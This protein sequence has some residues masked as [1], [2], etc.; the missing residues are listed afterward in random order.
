MKSLN[1][2]AMALVACM[3]VILAF[4]AKH[5]AS[6]EPPHVWLRDLEQPLRSL[7]VY[8]HKNGMIEEAAKF[9]ELQGAISLT[10]LPGVALPAERAVVALDEIAF[11]AE[12]A[13]R[14]EA[15]VG[16]GVDLTA[17][18]LTPRGRLVGGFVTRILAA[19][20]YCDFGVAGYAADSERRETMAL[21]RIVVCAPAAG[22]TP[23]DVRLAGLLT[24]A[25]AAK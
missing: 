10:R 23:P 5:A 16:D 18:P 17:V 1:I 6:A 19:D 8:R 24:L 21:A 3:V 12:A 13:R 4:A 25:D 15:A 2:V 14:F 7:I 11:L 20:G 9:T 22:M